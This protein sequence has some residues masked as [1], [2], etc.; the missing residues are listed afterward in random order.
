MKTQFDILE[1][2]LL[3][4]KEKKKKRKAKS[5]FVTFNKRSQRKAFFRLLPKSILQNKLQCVKKFKIKDHSIFIRDPPDPIN[6]NWKNFNLNLK[7]K[8]ARRCIS[9][10]VFILVFYIRKNLLTIFS[11]FYDDLV[12]F[13]ESKV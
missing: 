7:N 5:V 9:W 3:I 6:I 12:R 10:V 2:E 11:C 8:L 4:E 1:C 13:K